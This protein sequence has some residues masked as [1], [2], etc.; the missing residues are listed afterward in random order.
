MPLN[1]NDDIAKMNA[2][3]TCNISYGCYGFHLQVT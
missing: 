2:K 3:I 1:V